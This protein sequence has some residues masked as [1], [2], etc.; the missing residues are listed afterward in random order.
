M[1]KAVPNRFF[2]FT[3]SQTITCSYF[4][5]LFI[6]SQVFINVNSIRFMAPS[7]STR[8]EV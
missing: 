4:N 1:P 8:A 5:V 6:T 3:G 2:T 7:M